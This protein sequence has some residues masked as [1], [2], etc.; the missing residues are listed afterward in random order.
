MGL[1]VGFRWVSFHGVGRKNALDFKPTKAL[2]GR[3]GTMD[4]SQKVEPP[5]L[6]S[7]FGTLGPW[8][9]V[10][11]S[12]ESR[13]VFV[14]FGESMLNSWSVGWL[15]GRSQLKHGS[16]LAIERGATFRN[17]AYERACYSRNKHRYLAK[18]PWCSCGRLEAQN[19]LILAG[20]WYRIPF[21]CRVT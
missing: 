20:F 12:R 8:M 17:V 3:Q 21:V 6:F 9:D 4:L 10:K 1:M 14:F 18:Q 15:V 11:I 16:G 13:E 5:S 19:S 7:L 2:D